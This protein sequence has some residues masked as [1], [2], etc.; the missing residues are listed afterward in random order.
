MKQ[1]YLKRL[2]GIKATDIRI[3]NDME[4]KI[5]SNLVTFTSINPESFNNCKISSAYK[6]GLLESS[7]VQGLRCSPD[8]IGVIEDG[9]GNLRP[10]CIEAKCRTRLSTVFAELEFSFSS[11]ESVEKVVIVNAGSTEMKQNVHRDSEL[12]QIYHQAATLDIKDVILVVGDRRGVILK[13][14]WVVFDSLS[15]THFRS[16]AIDILKDSTGFVFDALKEKK[17]IEEFI[18]PSQRCSILGLRKHDEPHP[19]CLKTWE[20]MCVMPR[21]ENIM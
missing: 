2:N 9:D 20:M 5:I 21:Q 6:V 12:F 15:L 8:S 17:D 16:C 7:Y 14:V 1:S 10:V 18:S 19:T 4:D 11:S 13:V 3:G